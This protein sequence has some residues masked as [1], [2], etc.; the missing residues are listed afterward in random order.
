VGFFGFLS[1]TFDILFIFLTALIVSLLSRGNDRK[2]PVW[3][4]GIDQSEEMN[5]F[6]YAN[7]LRIILK[8][9]YLSREEREGSKYQERTFDIFW[10]FMIDLAKLYSRL[11]I[12]FGKF[13]MNGNI[14]RYVQ[15]IIIALFLVLIMVVI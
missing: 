9:V 6:A 15:Y 10:I 14:N 4:G 7:T 1:P 3:N 12:K 8:K 2:I 13:F 11:S 5:S